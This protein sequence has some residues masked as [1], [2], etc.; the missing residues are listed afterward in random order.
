MAPSDVNQLENV[1]K[2]ISDYTRWDMLCSYV[3]EEVRKSFITL[4]VQTPDTYIS[5]KSELFSNVFF[6]NN[7]HGFLAQLHRLTTL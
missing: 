1:V 2:L 5:Y 3:L 6:G 4:S 7:S